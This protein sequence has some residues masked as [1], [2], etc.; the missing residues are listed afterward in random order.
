MFKSKAL[1][2][3]VEEL[4]SEL[5]DVQDKLAVAYKDIDDKNIE[6]DHLQNELNKQKLEN[7]VSSEK[8]ETTNEEYK[9]LET[10]LKA[11]Q[12][13]RDE[14]FSQA[15][16][17]KDEILKYQ[18]KISELELELKSTSEVAE[19]NTKVANERILNLE[20]E[21]N[22]L[23]EKNKALE[24][25][26]DIKESLYEELRSLEASMSQEKDNAVESANELLKNVEDLKR[27]I[28][29]AKSESQSIKDM[30][31]DLEDERDSLKEVISKK[32]S[33]ICEK[34][35][36]IK[37]LELDIEKNKGSNNGVTNQKYLVVLAEYKKVVD[38]NETYKNEISDWSSKYDALSDKYIDLKEELNDKD[39]KIRELEE[40]LSIEKEK[41]KEP[42][43]ASEIDK[44][45][46]MDLLKM[47]GDDI[48]NL[49]K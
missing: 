46:Y 45:T 18:A 47:I 10:S 40:L 41:S 24:D 15:N 49:L 20:N 21:V 3:E 13:N 2:K 17:L 48:K 42:K 26:I 4:T 28:F 37:S 31:K 14:I 32:D 29:Q 12:E 11:L 1:L 9:K 19:T 33:I 43:D 34:D 7:E 44:D 27:E 6:I 30:I 16:V 23:K 35:E 39:A 22:D 8:L 36:R 5:K 38:E 25:T